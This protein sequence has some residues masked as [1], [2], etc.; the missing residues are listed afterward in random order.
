MRALATAIAVIFWSTLAASWAQTGDEVRFGIG[1]PED[2]VLVE[3]E[4][5][6]E[7]AQAQTLVETL[8]AYDAAITASGSFNVHGTT[9][10][11][12]APVPDA[13]AFADK[14]A[15]CQVL[16]IEDRRIRIS[17]DPNVLAQAAAG[18]AGLIEA[19]ASGDLSKV[20]ALLAAGVPVDTRDDDWVTPLIASARNGHLEVVKALLAAGADP[21]KDSLVGPCALCLA[22]RQG[23]KDV[24]DAIITAETD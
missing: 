23:H 20:E 9:S 22:L 8:L 12:L 7:A 13:R 11:T 24:V 14:I 1:A 2:G 18:A 5:A 3:V 19:A 6:L 10:I 21:C 4:E 15:C 17:V 16:S